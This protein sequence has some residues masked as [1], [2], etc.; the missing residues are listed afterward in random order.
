M[1][2]GRGCI[3]ASIFTGFFPLI[4]V[5]LLWMSLIRI[6]VRIMPYWS[7]SKMISSQHPQLHCICEDPFFQR[8]LHSQVLGSEYTFWGVTVQ[9]TNNFLKY[10]FVYLWLCWVFVAVQPTDNCYRLDVS[11]L[12]KFICWNL[13]P[14]VQ[15]FGSGAFGRWSGLEGG[16][17]MNGINCLIKEASKNF[18]TLFTR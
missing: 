17:L 2:L 16:A 10:L 6:L 1:F 9:P 12:L 5:S 11:V 4:Q 18:L 8:R 7:K 13:I 15:L 3:T 14:S